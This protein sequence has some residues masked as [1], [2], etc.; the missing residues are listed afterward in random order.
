MKYFDCRA[1]TEL[2]CDA[3]DMG[4]GACLMQGGQPVPH[5]SRAMTPAE[6]NIQDYV[7]MR[8]DARRR[9]PQDIW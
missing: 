2:Q 1:E 9:G 8:E 4:L 6:V 3:S 7:T 5:A